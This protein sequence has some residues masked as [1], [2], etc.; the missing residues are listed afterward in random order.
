ML[1][2]SKYIED[3][4]VPFFN[5]IDYA[6]F[7]DSNF[8]DM[9]NE[10][11]KFN[12]GSLQIRPLIEDELKTDADV[13]RKRV[14]NLIN[15]RKYK[16]T[17]LYDTT[18]LE[19]NPIENYSM[20]EEGTDTTSAS[21]TKTDDLGAY[22]DTTS[23]TDTNT[24]TDAKTEK[25]GTYEDAITSTTTNDIAKMTT[26]TKNDTTNTGSETHERKVAPFDSDTYSEQ[27]L[28][29]DTFKDRKN[30]TNAETIVSPHTD[31][32][33]KRDI[34]TGGARENSYTTSTT[35]E[36]QH[37][38]SHNIS[39]RINSYADESS[40]TTTHKFTR[41]GNIGVTTSQQM[42]ES[43]RDIALFNFIGIVAHDIIKSICICIY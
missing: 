12:H 3:N 17:R 19:Y 15:V 41:S 32:T 11:C 34:T 38:M 27:E 39:S 18:L 22:S 13:I 23:G 20:T 29:T 9:L 36:L 8:V 40:G 7:N 35:D 30:S 24:I 16:Y 31:T 10:W 14:T 33:T 2:L 5:T 28:N 25:I 43:E 42:L 4:E 6:P 21:G 26:T 37:G 1:T